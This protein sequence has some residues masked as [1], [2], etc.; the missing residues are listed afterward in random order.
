LTDADPQS[1]EDIRHFGAPVVQ[2]SPSMV[3][4]ISEIKAFL[5]KSM[6]RA[7]D[8]MEKRAEVTQVVDALFPHFL[9]HPGELPAR[10]QA[11]LAKAT[12]RTGVARI[13]ADYIAGMTDRFALATYAELKTRQGS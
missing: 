8:V 5:F 7:P 3:D 1:V 11:D 9:S 12:G 6:Y 2:F 13:V 4:A 10:W